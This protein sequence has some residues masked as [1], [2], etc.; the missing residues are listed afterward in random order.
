MKIAIPTKATVTESF[1]FVCSLLTL[2]NTVFCKNVTNGSMIYAIIR[3]VISRLIILYTKPIP[4]KIS[5][6]FESRKYSTTAEQVA[7]V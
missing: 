4:L 7:S 3:P 1:F 5:D 2:E 6:T